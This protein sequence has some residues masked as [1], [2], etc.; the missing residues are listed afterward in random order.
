MIDHLFS[1]IVD[2]DTNILSREQIKSLKDRFTPNLSA[3]EVHY[4]ECGIVITN[5]ATYKN[6]LYYAGFEYILNNEVTLVNDRG[7]FVA[8]F[9]AGN[10]R[11]EHI[12]EILNELEEKDDEE[13]P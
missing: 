5:E 3:R 7:D 2:C 11:V 13:M 8:V 4:G 9:W 1:N 6:W 12:L 10:S